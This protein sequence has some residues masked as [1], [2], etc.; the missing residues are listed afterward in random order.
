MVDARG[1]VA[2]IELPGADHGLQ[3]P[4]D[5]R[6]SMLDQVEIFDRIDHLAEQ[7]LA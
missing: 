6:R 3:Q 4:S 1:G 2:I 7:V 5:W